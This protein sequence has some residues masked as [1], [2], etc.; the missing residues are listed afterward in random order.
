MTMLNTTI[1]PYSTHTAHQVLPK[2]ATAIPQRILRLLP[3]AE[4][5]SITGKSRST[6]YRWIIEGNFPA[7]VKIGGNSV[8]WPEE[9]LVTWREKLLN[10]RAANDVRYSGNE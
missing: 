7:P 1:P 9:A 6:I 2:K 8:A 4:I 3:M 10:Q 5:L